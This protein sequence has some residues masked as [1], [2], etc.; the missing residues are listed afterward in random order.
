MSADYTHNATNC[1][2]VQ[3]HSVIHCTSVPGIGAGYRWFV[4]AATQDASLYSVSQT[5]YAS[6]TITNLTGQTLMPTRGLGAVV[7]RGDNFGRAVDLPLPVA[8]YGS[9]PTTFTAFNCTVT[10]DHYEITCYAVPGVGKNHQWQV[11][12]G[13]QVGYSGSS[14]TSYE[15]PSIVSVTVGVMNTSGGDVIVVS[16][17]NFGTDAS[18]NTP[19]IDFN[20]TVP[21]RNVACSVVEN[22]TRLECVAPP[23]VGKDLEFAVTVGSQR[24]PNKAT[25]LR[26][27]GPVI[28]AI[29]APP[30]STDGNQWVTLSG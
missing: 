9:N 15:E 17:T 30:L 22:H 20:S 11:T 10:V 14:L 21:Y 6:P 18:Y 27:A 2:I 3:N 19:F 26:Y 24:S 1:T 5:R 25:S 13:K 12:V 23:G 8:T 7:I 16:G 28:M 29:S 4:T